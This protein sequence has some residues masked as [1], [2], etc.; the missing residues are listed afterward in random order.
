LK[1]G[2][3]KMKS[4]EFKPGKPCVMK[5]RDDEEELF[6]NWL[7]MQS[8]YSDSLRYLVQKE[9]AEHGLRN[10][11]LIIPQFRTIDT[12]KSQLP[13]A[14]NNE[15]LTPALMNTVP[16]SIPP[17]AQLPGRDSN[18]VNTLEH[19]DSQ[20]NHSQIGTSNHIGTTD[21]N[22]EDK[23]VQTELANSKE[24]NIESSSDVTTGNLQES[25][26]ITK[27]KSGKTFSTDV[28]NSYA[29]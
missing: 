19:H 18:S 7:N 24:T 1:K 11:Q 20:N 9:I 13:M 4:T 25:P 16:L 3:K 21:D 5:L 8:M 22:K 26:I 29:N 14:T 28:K 23:I 6:L 2:V 27:R 12:L 15:E 17:S 10:L